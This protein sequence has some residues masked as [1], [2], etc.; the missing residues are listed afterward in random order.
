MD[1]HHCSFDNVADDD[2]SN[3]D[4]VDDDG[5]D[6]DAANEDRA[7]DDAVVDVVDDNF[8]PF[9]NVGSRS[10]VSGGAKVEVMCGRDKLSYIRTNKQLF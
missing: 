1:T 10:G 2:A 8:Y 7:D 4:A 9:A 5:T 6:D 3:T